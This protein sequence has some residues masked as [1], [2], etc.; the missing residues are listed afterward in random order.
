MGRLLY[1]INHLDGWQVIFFFQGQAGTGK[2]TIANICKAFYD[3]EDV[4]I[5]SNNVQRKFGLSDILDKKIFIAPEIKRDF[6]LE[7]AEFQS[8]VSGDTM[9]IAE[10]YKKSRFITWDTPGILAGNE[11][12]D[13]IDNYGSIQRRIISIRFV[14]KVA[15]GDMML[16]RKLHEEMAKIIHK[17]NLAYIDAYSKFAKDDIWKHIPSYFVDNRNAMAA[18]TNPLIHFL[19]SGKLTL[20][21]NRIMPEKE[22]IQY[23]NSHCVDNNYSK[24]RFN[25]D[26]YTG[27]FTQ[28]GI[29][30]V[31]KNT[32]FWPPEGCRGSKQITGTAFMGVDF[33]HDDEH[34]E[35]FE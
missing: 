12:P 4:G 23:F 9:S 31:K 27:P 32:F 6:C 33:L 15:N 8:M 16:G 1:K 21:E 5:L 10:K 28:F 25:P 20:D 35:E 7:Q 13:F 24:P 2:S 34:F 19:S 18:A 14:K 22:F 3:D 11:T 17:C 26:F 29:S 30:I